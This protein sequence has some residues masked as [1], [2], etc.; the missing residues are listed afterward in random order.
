[1][2]TLLLLILITVT[3][4]YDASN[5]CHIKKGDRLFY[6]KPLQVSP[7]TLALYLRLHLR[8]GGR[9]RPDLPIQLL[10]A[11]HPHRPLPLPQH[12]LQFRPQPP[13]QHLPELLLRFENVHVL[14]RRPLGREWQEHRDHDCGVHGIVPGGLKADE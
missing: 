3:A 9:H 10:H 8:L 7:C 1:M 5:R 14:H 11:I 6:L 4:S 12:L 2:F 13:R